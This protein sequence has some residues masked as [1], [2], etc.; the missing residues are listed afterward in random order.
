MILSDDV[1]TDCLTELK[2]KISEHENEGFNGRG[3]WCA[4]NFENAK[5]SAIALLEIDIAQLTYFQE[6]FDAKLHKDTYETLLDIQEEELHLIKSKSEDCA[7]EEDLQAYNES[8]KE[9]IELT[10]Q[11]I[12]ELNKTQE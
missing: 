10:Q 12:D 3:T 11:Y 4:E 5:Q 2:R 1:Y 7:D 8:N 9:Y 6:N